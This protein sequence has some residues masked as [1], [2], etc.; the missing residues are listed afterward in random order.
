MIG[1][2]ASNVKAEPP[3]QGFQPFTYIEPAVANHLDLSKV[4]AMRLLWVYVT[5]IKRT[6]PKRAMNAPVSAR[7]VREEERSQA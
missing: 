6:R 3:G 2:A 4:G 7:V 5:Q 1:N